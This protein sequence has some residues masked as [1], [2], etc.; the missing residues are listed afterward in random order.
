MTVKAREKGNSESWTSDCRLFTKEKG[1][2]TGA[3]LESERPFLPEWSAALVVVVVGRREQ[4]CGARSGMRGAHRLRSP[5]RGF[6]G[7]WVPSGSGRGPQH[8]S[9]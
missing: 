4:Y 5:T 1:K 3:K 6:L 9:E 8:D 7:M 2:D